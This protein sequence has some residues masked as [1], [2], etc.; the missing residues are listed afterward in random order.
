LYGV[1]GVANPVTYKFD[2]AEIDLLLQI[3]SLIGSHLA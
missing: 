2:Q 3:G 1:L